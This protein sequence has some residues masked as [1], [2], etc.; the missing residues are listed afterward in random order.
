MKTA[1]GVILASVLYLFVFN[2]VY[3]PGVA[4]S[5]LLFALLGILVAL[6]VIEGKIGVW[7]FLLIGRN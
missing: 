7:T 1:T 2:I 5:A 6:L 3:I 4:L